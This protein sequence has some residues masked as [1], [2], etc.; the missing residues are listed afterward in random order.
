MPIIQASQ[1]RVHELHGASFISYVRPESGSREL[2]AWRVEVSGRTEGVAHQ[3]SREEVLFI[4][5][6]TARVALNDDWH[7]AVA[8]DAI[9]VPAGSRFRVDNVAE[10]PMTAW[11]T[12]TPGFA[13]VMPDGSWLTPPWTS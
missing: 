12:T 5:S 9:V 3:V 10:E 6:G 7:D 2:C 4:L 1:A 8:G 11:V 13:A